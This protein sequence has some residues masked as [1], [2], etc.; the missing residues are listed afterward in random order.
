MNKGFIALAVVVTVT[1]ILMALV[2]SSSVESGLFFDQAMRKKYRTMNYYY[3]GDC[4]DQAVLMLAHDYF[5]EFD[6][7]LEPLEIEGY[8]CEIITVRA[9]G[10]TRNIVA[11]GNF[12]K[13]YAYRTASVLLN[14]HGLEIIE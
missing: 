1:G 13:A 10:N 3:A 11:R 7:P 14:D 2:F 9:V 8:H 12:Q 5:F 4:L 6:N